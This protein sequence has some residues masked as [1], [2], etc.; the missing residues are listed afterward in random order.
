MQNLSSQ[1]AAKFSKLTRTELKDTIESVAELFVSHG[2]TPYAPVVESFFRFGG[3]CIPFPYEYGGKFKLYRP[4]Q[5]IKTMVG[6][7]DAS[8]HPDRFRICFGE[9][10]TIQ[11]FFLM[12]GYGRLYED[13]RPI[14]S[15][16]VEWI[17][18]WASSD[19]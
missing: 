13:D 1:A 6:P 9:S 16:I 14:A 12:D 18:E 3:Y 8:E 19:P 5:A 11:A 7:C 10:A 4:K 2:L 17:E 15:D